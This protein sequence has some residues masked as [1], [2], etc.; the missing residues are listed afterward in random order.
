MN[1]LNNG[2]NGNKDSIK[3]NGTKHPYHEKTI[4]YEKVVYLAY[5]S[6]PLNDPNIIY[7]VTWVSNPEKKSGTMVAGD[8]VDILKG[9]KFNV[10]HTSRS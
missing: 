5:G 4:S 3:V 2:N 9:M 1:T 7:T 10:K 8:V 6:D